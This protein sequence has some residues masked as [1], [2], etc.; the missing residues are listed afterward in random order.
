[1]GPERF[2]PRYYLGI[3]VYH[4]AHGDW[5]RRA[6]V[7]VTSYQPA[8]DAKLLWKP[9]RQGQNLYDSEKTTEIVLLMRLP[10][11]TIALSANVTELKKGKIRRF[12]AIFLLF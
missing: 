5:V 3:R 4:F 8:S 7:N 10:T 6:G 11:Q 1:M 12:D 9:C 2:S